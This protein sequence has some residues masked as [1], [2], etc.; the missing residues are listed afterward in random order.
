MV[1]TY[2]NLHKNEILLKISEVMEEKYSVA[3]EKIDLFIDY[4]HNVD[5]NQNLIKDHSERYIECF[6]GISSLHDET[7]FFGISINNLTSLQ[8]Y[9]E[10]KG[11]HRAG[12]QYFASAIA[13][14]S[15]VAS[16]A[17]Y[18]FSQNLVPNLVKIGFSQNPKR[19]LNEVRK[20]V[21]S[22]LVAEELVVLRKKIWKKYNRLSDPAEE[23]KYIS[24]AN[25]KIEKKLIL[26]IA[27]ERNV[28]KPFEI[29]QHLHGKLCHLVSTNILSDSG[30]WFHLSSDI[31]PTLID[32]LINDF[33]IKNR[34][35]VSL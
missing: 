34:N 20:R 29:E 26:R 10:I 5:N 21:L 18:V 12:E 32:N 24:E 11:A 14:N 22:A 19:R 6:K 9:F 15:A 31:A 27:Y 2:F 25:A 17:I 3:V 4:K 8:H 13:R 30:E 33:E 23:K 28:S 35:S 16:G 1:V 7:F